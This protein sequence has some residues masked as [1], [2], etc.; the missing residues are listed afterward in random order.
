MASYNSRLSCTCPVQFFTQGA[1]D[2]K[3][4]EFILP[5]SAANVTFYAERAEHNKFEQKAVAQ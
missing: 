1:T 2:D 5:N 3:S 4:E